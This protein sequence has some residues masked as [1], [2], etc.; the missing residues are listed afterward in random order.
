MKGKFYRDNIKPLFDWLASLL[1]VI[2]CSPLFFLISIL[3]LINN[4]KILY[5]QIRSGK[6]GKPFKLL[7]FCTM[8]DERDETGK[9][10]PD[11]IR[12]T[13][14]GEYLRKTSLDELPQL[15]NV[16]TGQM[17]LIGPR[18]LPMEYIPL[19]SDTQR[20]RLEVKPG[21]TGWAQVNGR[22]TIDW[23]KKF[24][25]DIW[26]IENQS[27]FLDL[28]ILWLTFKK[29]IMMEGINQSATETMQPFTGNQKD[30]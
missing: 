4:G 10:L 13:R 8:T 22:N 26:Y 1:L 18:P 7:K 28:L 12:T 27:F 5:A 20:K 21:I 11:V 14:V 23:D 2:L 24:M 9:L 3:V 16:L 25:Y 19:Y 30:A 17:S 15:F 6:D 29:V